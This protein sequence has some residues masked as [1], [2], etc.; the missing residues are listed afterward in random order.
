MRETTGVIQ[1]SKIEEIWQLLRV[2]AV[3]SWMKRI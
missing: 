1:L 2:I 3:T